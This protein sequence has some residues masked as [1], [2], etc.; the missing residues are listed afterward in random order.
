MLDATI[1][2]DHD[3]DYNNSNVKIFTIERAKPKTAVSLYRSVLVSAWTSSS[4]HQ[5]YWAGCIIGT[6]GSVR[7]SGLTK[8][9]VNLLRL[10][11]P[12]IPLDGWE[13][14]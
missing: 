6:D 9:G 3:V 8:A 4:G 1:I 2:L 7:L 5:S 13:V 10:L 14:A 12:A 11:V